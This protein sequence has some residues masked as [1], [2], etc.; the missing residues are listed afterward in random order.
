MKNIYV[1]ASTDVLA[2]KVINTNTINTANVP[3]VSVND[4]MYLNSCICQDNVY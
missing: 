3:E 4:C 2:L 1:Q